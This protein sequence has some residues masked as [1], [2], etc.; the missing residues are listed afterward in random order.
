MHLAATTTAIYLAPGTVC[1]SFY[2]GPHR[3]GDIVSLLMRTTHVART[4]IAPKMY[5]AN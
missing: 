2:G 3:A 1:P 4:R 5:E